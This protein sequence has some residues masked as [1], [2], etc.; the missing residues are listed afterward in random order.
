M[1][2]PIA[3]RPPHDVVRCRIGD[4]RKLSRRRHG[5][6]PPSKDNT[7]RWSSPHIPNTSTF[8]SLSCIAQ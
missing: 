3:S 6:S 1:R 8:A 4:V 5:A 7:S 2:L